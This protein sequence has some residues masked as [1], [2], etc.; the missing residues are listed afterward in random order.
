MVTAS[1]SSVIASRAGPSVVLERSRLY[2]I[3]SPSSPRL[4]EAAHQV[5]R[6][7]R[8]SPKTEKAYVGWIRRYVD[9]HGNRHPKEMGAD[10]IRVFVSWLAT[11]RNVSASTQ[12]QALSALLFLY[13]DVLRET[14]GWIEDIQLA[15]ST[16]RLPVVLTRG[17]V[18]AVLGH[19]YGIKQLMASLLYGAGLRVSECCGLRI[20]DVDCSRREIIVRDGKGR[21][22]RVTVLPNA[23]LDPLRLHLKRVKRVH[24]AD[25]WDG[26]GRVDLPSAFERKSP[27]AASEFAWQWVFPSRRHYPDRRTGEP[28]RHHKHPATLQRAVRRAVNRAGI[29]KRATCHT[30]RHSFATHLLES[31]TDIRTIQELLGHR[32]LSTTMIYT[33][34]LNRGG[35]GVRSPLDAP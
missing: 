10:E 22:D 26:T 8:L 24:L 17:E 14:V 29:A 4:L 20:K 23:T 12:N 13:R 25:L 16:R 11:D 15:K 19:M 1:G 35:L 27:K 34:V 2:K 7:K 5:I 3:S 28:K 30:L 32:D 21:K 31:G 6:T 9:F 18:E 33:H